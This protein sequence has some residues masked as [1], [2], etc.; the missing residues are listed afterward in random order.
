MSMNLFLDRI[1]SLDIVQRGSEFYYSIQK[2][3]VNVSRF[4]PSGTRC[5]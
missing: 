2:I 3:Y 1:S 5:N 4:V